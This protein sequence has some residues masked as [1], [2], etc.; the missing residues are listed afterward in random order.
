MKIISNSEI[1]VERWNAFLSGNPFATPFQTFDF[2]RVVNSVARM[3]A[4]AVAVCNEDNLLAL[5]V[6]TFPEGTGA[7]AFFARRAIIYGGPV[8][9]PRYPEAMDMLISCLETELKGKVIYAETR[10]LSDYSGFR[11]I[12]AKHRWSY[13][14]Y[15]NYIVRTDNHDKMVRSVS[16]SRM[17]KIRHAQAAGVTW[18]QAENAEE[19]K[20]L[21]T[22]MKD[23][24]RKKVRKPLLPWEFF[25]QFLEEKIGVILLV[26]FE[27]KIIGGIVCPVFERRSIYEFY[28]CGFDNDY[29]VQCPSI[30]AT[31]AA[32]EY[33]SLNGIQMFDFM[34]AGRPD[35]DYGV[36]EF[37]ARFGGEMAE[38]GRFR[39]IMNPLLYR[40]GEMVINFRSVRHK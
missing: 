21:Y 13:V 36:R 2:Y 39:R 20:A 37:K 31:W 24:Y 12:F 10:N 4:R 35:E 16:A 29:K 7:K 28:V 17:R 1:P 15:L 30:M 25:E 18:K 6:I 11:E 27:E 8:A 3:S 5:A 34:G 14:P 9:D 23:L 32:M 26:I 38:Y 33:A 19:T 22:I 40:M